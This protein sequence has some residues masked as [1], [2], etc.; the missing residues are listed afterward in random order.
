VTSWAAA[1]LVIYV[2]LGLGLGRG[3]GD[4]AT[5]LAICITTIVLAVVMVHMG[6]SS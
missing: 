5:L 2:V 6:A 4:K 3:A 1:L